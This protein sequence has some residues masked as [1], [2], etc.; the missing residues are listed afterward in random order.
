MKYDAVIFDLFGTLVPTPDDEFEVDHRR[1]AAALGVDGDLY[2]SAWYGEELTLKRATGVLGDMRSMIEA[3]CDKLNVTPT[4]EAIALW[5]E[6]RMK[7]TRGVL[8]PRADARETLGRLR[9]MG[10]RLGMMSDCSC[11]VPLIWGETPMA[12]WIDEALFSCREGLKKPDPRFYRAACERLSVA[13]ERCLFVGD[14]ACP[15]LTGAR[16][17]GMDAVLIC[18]PAERHIIMDRDET[19]KWTGPRIAALSEL[20]GLVNSALDDRP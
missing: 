13:A 18:P 9:G 8:K 10:L 20:S 7:V 6:H 2:F 14:G 15:E 4:P 5:V 12:E 11:E 3:V 17:V 19:R 16:R 1:T